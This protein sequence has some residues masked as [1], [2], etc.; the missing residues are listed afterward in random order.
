VKPTKSHAYSPTRLPAALDTGDF[1]I[2]PPHEGMDLLGAFIG[3]KAWVSQQLLD[4]TD[5][6]IGRFWRIEL[7]SSADLYLVQR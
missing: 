5:D 1:V 2:H 3:T 4:L 6:L 7:L